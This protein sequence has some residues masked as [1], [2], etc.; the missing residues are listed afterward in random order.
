VEKLGYIIIEMKA[1]SE[2]KQ[3]KYV[4]ERTHQKKLKEYQEKV[5]VS[6]TSNFN[7]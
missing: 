4:L 5:K 7:L 6:S 3:D 1:T 2:T